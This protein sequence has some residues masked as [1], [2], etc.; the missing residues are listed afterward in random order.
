MSEHNK[1]NHNFLD[2]IIIEK[3]EF[4]LFVLPMM[5]ALCFITIEPSIGLIGGLFFLLFMY[6]V[7]CKIDSEY[8]KYLGY[9]DETNSSWNKFIPPLH[10]TNR[11]ELLDKQQSS[12]LKNTGSFLASIISFLLVG[13][14]ITYANNIEGRTCETVTEIIQSQWGY[15]AECEYVEL[16]EITK[17][18]YAG[19][20]YLNDGDTVS[21]ATH[22]SKDGEMQ[23]VVTPF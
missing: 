1:I 6:I 23:V 3:G 10:L 14:F 19:T 18:E 4:I 20:A 9:I 15:T 17:N 13:W 11:S 16:E 12:T 7:I 22:K 21:V 5:L 8:L 2:H